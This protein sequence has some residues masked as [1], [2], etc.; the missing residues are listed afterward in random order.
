MPFLINGICGK[1]SSDPSEKAKCIYSTSNS[2][3][4]Y[5][6]E[7]DYDSNLHLDSRPAECICNDDRHLIQKDGD[8][9][10]ISCTGLTPHFNKDTSECEPDCETAATGKIFKK[11]LNCH[12]PEEIP[13][14]IEGKCYEGCPVEK[15]AVAPH[16]NQSTST[17]RSGV[18][19][20]SSTDS[21]NSTQGEISLMEIKFDY[22]NKMYRTV[23]KEIDHETGDGIC[24]CPPDHPNWSEKHKTCVECSHPANKFDKAQGECYD[25]CDKVQGS[26]WSYELKACVCPN[27]GQYALLNDD[28]TL[29]CNTCKEPLVNFMF[30]E[31]INSFIKKGTCNCPADHEYWTP[32]NNYNDAKATGESG[33][34]S[35]LPDSKCIQCLPPNDQLN[36]ETGVCEHSCTEGKAPCTDA[37]LPNCVG[38]CI[39]PENTFLVEDTLDFG[40]GM[41]DG[42]KKCL[43]VPPTMQWIPRPPPTAQ[44]EATKDINTACMNPQSLDKYEM[45]ASDDHGKCVYS[46]T[47]PYFVSKIYNENIDCQ[48]TLGDFSCPAV[49]ERILF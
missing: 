37:Q 47:I 16:S 5:Q 26:Q 18:H 6:E 44:I 7:C 39:C 31:D 13:L 17:S 24:I 30:Q 15:N 34:P 46:L 40:A 29:Q 8:D 38:K 14:F 32:P 49:S 23:F 3:D 28:G 22:S 20:D 41:N 4:G 45:H 36:L 11:G 9:V 19:N 10:C 35:K 25:E 1:C 27:D 21:L 43:P 33:S 48:D 2:I 12:C 42:M